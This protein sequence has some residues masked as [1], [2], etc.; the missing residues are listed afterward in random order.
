MKQVPDLV[1]FLFKKIQK[2]HSSD[3][4]ENHSRNDSK[5]NVNTTFASAAGMDID[6]SRPDIKLPSSGAQNESEECKHTRPRSTH[7]Y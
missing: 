5:K 1:I 7:K 6:N 3:P 4:I 2:S